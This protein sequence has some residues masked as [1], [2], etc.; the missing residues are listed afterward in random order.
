MPKDIGG[1]AMRGG[2][3]LLKVEALKMEIMI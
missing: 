2:R 1:D 3:G